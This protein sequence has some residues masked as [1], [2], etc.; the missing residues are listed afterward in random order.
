MILTDIYVP[1]VN[2]GYDFMLDETLS[3]E[4]AMT[5]ICE[6]IAKKTKSELTCD[7]LEFSLYRMDT[8]QII[9]PEMSLA[10]AGINDGV[11][12]MLI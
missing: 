7:S 8:G 11:R 9:S 12:L 2:E 10:H 4:A 5:E 3:A 6:M 1:S